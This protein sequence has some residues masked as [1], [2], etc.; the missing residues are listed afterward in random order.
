MSG[1][2]RTARSHHLY[3][4]TALPPYT[5]HTTAGTLHP[6]LLH[7]FERHYPPSTPLP[8]PCTHHT[9]STSTPAHPPPPTFLPPRTLRRARRASMRRLH[10]SNASPGQAEHTA[11]PTIT[12]HLALFALAVWDWDGDLPFCWRAARLAC[13]TRNATTCVLTSAGGG[14]AL[15]ARLTP[16]HA[17][18]H[19]LLPRLNLFGAHLVP[20]LR[21]S[22]ALAPWRVVVG[23]T[24]TW[25]DTDAAPACYTGS[26]AAISTQHGCL[27][28]CWVV[29]CTHLHSPATTS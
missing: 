25:L 14:Q 6:H 28:D 7:T 22:S 19:L 20:C 9:T 27:L 11:P 17:A 3:R 4:C 18:C 16:A 10:S 13:T 26:R 8:L 12:Q 21:P 29:P 24:W 23:F 2:G 15:V 1:S 5:Y